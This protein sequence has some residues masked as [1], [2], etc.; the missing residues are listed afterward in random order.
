MQSSQQWTPVVNFMTIAKK[1]LLSLIYS[2]TMSKFL[3]KLPSFLSLN[4]QP[5]LSLSVRAERESLESALF[6]GQEL[7]S[8]LEADQTR[9]EGER[10]SLQQANEALTCEYLSGSLWPPENSPHGAHFSHIPQI[11]FIRWS[12]ETAGLKG[13]PFSSLEF[14][15]VPSQRVSTIYTIYMSALSLCIA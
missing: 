15:T 9:L 7:I 13:Q 3:K 5:L 2:S 6:D 1:G 14:S 8:S 12:S 11:Y 4:H 10:G